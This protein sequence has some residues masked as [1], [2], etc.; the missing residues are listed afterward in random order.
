M[1]D[2]NVTVDDEWQSFETPRRHN[3]I[4]TALIPQVPLGYDTPQYKII[5]NLYGMSETPYISEG[6]YLISNLW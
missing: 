4:A 5:T 2:T 3:H 1:L 6:V